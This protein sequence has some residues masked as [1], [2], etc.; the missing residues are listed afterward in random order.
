MDILQDVVYDSFR[1]SDSTCLPSPQPMG[2]LLK[3]VLQMMW[4]TA[5]GQY[6]CIT[7]SL[8]LSVPV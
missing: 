1:S 2:T 7:L 8:S 6:I 4:Y 5:S 3:L